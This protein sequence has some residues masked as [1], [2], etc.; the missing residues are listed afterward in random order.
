MGVRKGRFSMKRFEKGRMWSLASSWMRRA[1]RRGWL[2]GW[3]MWGVGWAGRYLRTVKATPRRWPRAERATRTGRAFVPAE[4]PKMFLKRLA[5]TVTLAAVISALDTPA[6][7]GK[8]V[9]RTPC[10]WV[11]RRGAYICDVG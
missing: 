2:D 5:A 10:G 4:A 7:C 6:N 8:L 9:L 1:G 11:L 3:G